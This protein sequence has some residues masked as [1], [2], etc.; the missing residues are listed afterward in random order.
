MYTATP[1]QR[2]RERKDKAD[3]DEAFLKEGVLRRSR[4]GSTQSALER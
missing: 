4:S 3:K 2:K 1:E